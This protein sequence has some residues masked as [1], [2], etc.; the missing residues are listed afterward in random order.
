MEDTP[1]KVRGRVDQIPR[2]PLTQG[3]RSPEDNVLRNQRIDAV[4]FSSEKAHWPLRWL[5]DCDDSFSGETDGRPLN[6]LPFEVL[7]AFR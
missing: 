5:N 6:R 3:T 4:T 2:K 1:L 7:N